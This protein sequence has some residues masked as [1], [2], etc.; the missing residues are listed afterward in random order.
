MSQ[1]RQLAAI[2]FT[3]I[4][5][6]TAIMGHDEHRA[7][8]MLKNNR[9]LQK[10][11]IEEYHGRWIKEIGDGIMSCFHSVSDAVHA[12]LKIQEA[13]HAATDFQLRIGIHLGEVVFENEDIFGDGV[14]I[15]SRIQ[16]MAQPG[17]IYVSETVQQN[18]SNNPGIETRF[19]KQEVLKNVKEPVRIYEVLVRTL[20]TTSLPHVNPLV[21][22][23][24]AVLP[25]INM[26]NDPEQDYFSD[27]LTIELIT[28]LSKLKHIRII[29]STTSMQY[30][31]TK[32]DIQVIGKEINVR[33]ILEGSVRKHEDNLRITAQLIEV[34]HDTHLWA[35]TYK[36]KLADVFEIQEQV[37]RQIIEALEVQLSP[38]EEV[39]LSKRA[40]L[41][42][43]AFD[44]YL[45]AR[46]FL[47]R[48]TKNNILFAIQLFQKVIEFDPGYAEAYAGL[49]ESYAT[50]YQM[51]E[52]KE[53]WLEKA[54]ASSLQALEHDAT[55]S[56]AYAALA[57][58]YYNQKKIDESMAAAQQ[59]IKL[60]INSFRAYW[61][62]GRIYHTTDR[63]PMAVEMFKRVIDLH[64]DFYIAY[65]DLM[66]VYERLGEKERFGEL[67]NVLGRD[68]FPRYLSKHPDDARARINYASTLVQ[69]GETEQARIEAANALELTSDDPVVMYN[70]ACFYSRLHE[71]LLAV[72][73]FKKAVAAGFEHYDW[74]RR[75]P[76]LDNIREE[77]EYVE[78]MEGR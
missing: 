4:V 61:I 20:P 9:E 35:E 46:D 16:T 47:Y 57:V 75:D 26:S 45:R 70:A 21:D 31:G 41:K 76:D 32:K 54:I 69:M 48:R 11:I 24:M 53:I 50:Y 72:K 7:F 60:D 44:Y 1:T 59:A 78:F 10:P 42:P 27:G 66:A 30:K 33:Y 14:N 71:N 40:T 3:D 17:C 22:K 67:M 62:L 63:D 52:R 64:P 56:D 43:E 8:E 23:S 73:M 5:G 15:A 2:M 37:S 36:G 49:G 74:F 34:S 19:V 68:V 25:F 55:S 13:C 18:I 38:T 51:C 29:S 28:N 12:A 65:S 77:P 6:Y 39:V 58:A